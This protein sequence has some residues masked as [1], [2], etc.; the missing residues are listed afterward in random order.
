MFITGSNKRTLQIGA[1][2]RLFRR[3]IDCINIPKIANKTE[4]K[5]INT[6]KG[7]WVPSCQLLKKL[8]DNT[9]TMKG[10]AINIKVLDKY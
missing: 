1:L 10:S 2:F 4:I 6:P 3:F 5:A 9:V 8:D 7:K